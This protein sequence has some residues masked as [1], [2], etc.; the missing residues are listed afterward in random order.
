MAR[1]RSALLQP[2][3][4]NGVFLLVTRLLLPPLLPPHLSF[5]V[6]RLAARVGIWRGWEGLRG[7]KEKLA[8]GVE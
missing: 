3:P 4:G 1:L 2:R 8:G 5:H 7:K 6:E